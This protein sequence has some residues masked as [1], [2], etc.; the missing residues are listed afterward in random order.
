MTPYDWWRISFHWPVVHGHHGLSGAEKMKH[1]SL[2]LTYIGDYRYYYSIVVSTYMWGI[3]ATVIHLHRWPLNWLN[4]Q[5]CHARSSWVPHRA[6][7]YLHPSPRPLFIDKTSACKIFPSLET[8]RNWLW[9]FT[10]ASV[11]VLSRYSPVAVLPR[12][13]SNSR[14]IVKLP[15]YILHWD[16]TTRRFI[17]LSE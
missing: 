7:I 14:A 10:G 8:A 6:N 15:T 2:H 4:V 3:S 9:N 17:L 1:S 12:R 11:A 5:D 16:L 13:M